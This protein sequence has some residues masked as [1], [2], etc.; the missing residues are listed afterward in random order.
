MV[1][2]ML[3]LPSIEYKPIGRFI[4][5]LVAYLGRVRTCAARSAHNLGT[6]I[7]ANAEQDFT[8]TDGYKGATYAWT[9]TVGQAGIGT[10]LVSLP[11]LFNYQ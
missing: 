4:G 6:S 10:T 3:R 5:G 1:L 7:F 8:F 11:V 9:V 2:L